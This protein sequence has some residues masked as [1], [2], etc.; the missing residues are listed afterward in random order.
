[1]PE[2]PKAAARE[3]QGLKCQQW[4]GIIAVCKAI[5]PASGIQRDPELIENWWEFW[6]FLV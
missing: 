5:D 1:L 6:P 2:V 4:G 3:E